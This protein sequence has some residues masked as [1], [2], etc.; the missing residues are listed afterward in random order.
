M[1]NVSENEVLEESK[2]YLEKI[3]LSLNPKVGQECHKHYLAG[4]IDRLSDEGKISQENRGILY[5]TYVF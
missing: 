3:M 4:V 5:E 2:T 1:D